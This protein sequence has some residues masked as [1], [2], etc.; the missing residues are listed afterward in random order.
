KKEYEKAFAS[1]DVIVG[2]VSSETAFP[3]GSKTAD[4]LQMYL[5]DALTVP[6]NIAGVPAMSVP[7][8]MTKNNLPVGLQIIA[9]HFQ[10]EVMFQVAAAYEDAHDWKHLAPPLPQ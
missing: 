2:P 8:G 9:P 1:V 7:C 6:I 5:A 3:L 4:P 10:E